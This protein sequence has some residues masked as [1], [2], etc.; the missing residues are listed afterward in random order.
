MKSDFFF[1]IVC[2]CVRFCDV[3][4]E[5]RRGESNRFVDVFGFLVS[6]NAKKTRLKL[7]TNY[8]YDGLLTFI[9]SG[10]EERKKT[11][12]GHGPMSEERAKDDKRCEV[13]SV[14]GGKED[15]KAVSLESR[16]NEYSK[17]LLRP[18]D[19]LKPS[20]FDM[21]RLHEQAKTAQRFLH[22]N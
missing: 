1:K 2:V 14:F 13:I 11:N 12:F 21:R 6:S 18:F 20:V 7:K 10:S 16:L 15:F 19:T 4:I 8:A 5:A 17:S 3:E 9:L 22:W